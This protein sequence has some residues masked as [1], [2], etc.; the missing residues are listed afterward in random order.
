MKFK[1]DS[2]PALQEKLSDKLVGVTWHGSYYSCVCPFHTSFPVRNSMFVY[3]DAYKCASCGAYG[4]LQRLEKQLSGQKVNFRSDDDEEVINELPKWFDWKKEH[5]SYRQIAID[6]WH[7]G[8]KFSVLMKYLDKRCL[9]SMIEPA[10]IGYMNGWLTFP[11]WNWSGR[12]VDL[13]VRATPAVQTT[14]KYVLRPRQNKS[15]GFILYCVDWQA[16]EDQDVVYCPFG[17]LDMLTLS[18]LGYASVTGVTGKAYRAEWFDEIRK[19]I[20]IIPDLGEEDAAYK[21]KSQLGWRASVMHYPYHDKCTDLNDELM[22]HG[23]DQ[24]ILTL[25]E[26]SHATTSR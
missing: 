4:S 25:Q 26:K 3:Q 12:I 20:V 19:K 23:K 22:Y 18:M 15:E 24:V 11:M 13:V 21:L 10:H 14:S 8:Q 1:S 17:I 7:V 9:S 6:A 5:G 2:N 16:V